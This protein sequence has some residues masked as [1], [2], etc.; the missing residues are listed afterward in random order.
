[1]YQRAYAG[2]WSRRTQT[3]RDA[4]LVPPLDPEHS[5]PTDQQHFA[6]AP[7]WAANAPAPDLPGD[8][9]GNEALGVGMPTGWGPID[10]TPEGGDFGVGVGPG[11]SVLESMDV[12]REVH[13]ADY[14]AVAAHRWMHVSDTDG[15]NHLDVLVDPGTQDGD[16]PQTLDLE[17]TGYGRPND[18][19]ARRGR[20]FKRWNDRKIDMHRWDPAMRP[21]VP[22]YAQPVQPQAPVMEGNQYTGP[23]ATSPAGRLGV[24]DSF[25]GPVQ[26]RRPGNWDES[27]STDGT[28]A[29]LGGAPANYGLTSFG[30]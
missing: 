17:R 13:S 2:A 12:M 9:V 14:G 10:H 24:T 23:F 8:V 25:V 3:D 30:L 5:A 7:V 28:S 4:P 16:S 19:G 6:M 20:W 29:A 22:R 15:R 1:M 26:R 11:L 18:P 27:M 21:Q